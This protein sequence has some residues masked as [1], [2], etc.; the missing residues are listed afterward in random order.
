[1]RRRCSSHAQLSHAHASV[2]HVHIRAPMHMLRPYT[3][4]YMQEFLVQ[5]GTLPLLITVVHATTL[6]NSRHGTLPERNADESVKRYEVA[7]L[8]LLQAITHG[9]LRRG[10]RAYTIVPLIHRSRLDLNRGKQ[11]HRGQRAYDDHAAEGIYDRFDALVTTTLARAIPTGVPGVLIDLHGCTTHAAD[12]FMGS[13]HGET[14][15]Q[16]DGQPFAYDAIRCMM[17]ERGWRVAPPP[18]EPETRYA[19]HPHGV[20]SRHNLAHNSRGSS[21]QLEVSRYI[22]RDALLI[23][24]FGDDLAA[25]LIQAL[26]PDFE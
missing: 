16:I 6:E 7:L 11:W 25:A 8:P 17:N 19:G 22:R 3:P 20:I 26:R 13:L 2:L 24:R 18:G 23:A 10:G 1:M 9:L 15:S 4:I 21:I 5:N 14:L 12:L